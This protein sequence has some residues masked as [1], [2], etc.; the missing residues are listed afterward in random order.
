[1]PVIAEPD[2]NA[3]APLRGLRMSAEEFLAIPDDGFNY[4]LVSGV[5]VM[6]P[7]PIPRHQAVAGEI[8]TQIALF[9][10]SNPVGQVLAE[11][12]VFLGRDEA[13]R[14][15][16]YKPEVVFLTDEQWARVGDRIAEPPAVTVEV[17]SRGSRQLD[18]KTKKQDYERFGV[19]EYW[20]IDPERR[21]M[22]FYRLQDGRYVEAAP[23]DQKFASQAI[24]GFSLDLAEIAELF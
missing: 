10:R 22:T 21:T 2:A 16:V 23:A 7:S 24:P 19:R 17:I 5:V 14:D 20:L 13:G 15:L 8:F 6:S 1:M 12:D 11:I 4:E 3:A 18:T 9:L